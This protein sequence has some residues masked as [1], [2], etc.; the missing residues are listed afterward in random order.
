MNN[1][2]TK[3]L[4]EKYPKIFSGKDEPLT[5]NL[6][7]F[8]FEC[9]DG[10]F[11]LID[12]LCSILTHDIEHNDEPQIKAVQ[13]KEKYGTLRFYVQGASPRQYGMIDFAEYL[14]GAICEECGLPGELCT[15]TGNYYGW[16]R[17]LCSECAIN[18]K[19]KKIENE[20]Q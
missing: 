13:I 17:T 10:W 6:M 18:S 5:Q 19:Y 15:T 7:G 1:K 3:Y 16:Y 11:N 8:G 9:G 12:N 4:F 2:N 20:Q 14:S